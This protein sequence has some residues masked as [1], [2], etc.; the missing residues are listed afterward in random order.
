[1]QD[2]NYLNKP[3]L[4]SMNYQTT[5]FIADRLVEYLSN[6]VITPIDPVINNIRRLQRKLRI[7][8]NVPYN[9]YGIWD[10]RLRN[11]LYAYDVDKKNVNNYYDV[12]GYLDKNVESSLDIEVIKHVDGTEEENDEWLIR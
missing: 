8:Q 4:L 5:Y 6:N 1:M 10:D 7:E 12:L 9:H 11:F 2:Y 3:Q